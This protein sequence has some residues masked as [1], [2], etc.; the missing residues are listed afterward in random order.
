MDWF[1][2]WIAVD[3]LSLRRC[4]TARRRAAVTLRQWPAAFRFRAAAAA[5]SCRRA[6]SD[7][8]DT[9]VVSTVQH[10]AGAVW[11]PL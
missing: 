4:K 11:N 3:R 5:S 9:G 1:L 2:R 6:S 8:D 7:R 10:L